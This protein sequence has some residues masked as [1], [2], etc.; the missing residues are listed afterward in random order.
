MGTRN[1]AGLG[2]GLGGRRWAS[3]SIVVHKHRAEPEVE[4]RALTLAFKAQAALEVGAGE[5]IGEAGHALPPARRATNSRR[6]MQ[7]G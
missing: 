6:P 7:Q 5:L 4:G 3:S 2:R 1:C